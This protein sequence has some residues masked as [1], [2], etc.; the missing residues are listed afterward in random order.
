MSGTWHDVFYHSA[1]YFHL[2]IVL[3][4]CRDE[5]WVRDVPHLHTPNIF[6][7]VHIWVVGGYDRKSLCHNLRFFKAYT[8]RLLLFCRLCLSLQPSV[9]ICFLRRAHAFEP[10]YT[11]VYRWPSVTRKQIAWINLTFHILLVYQMS[12]SAQ[13]MFILLRFSIV[14]RPETHKQARPKMSAGSLTFAGHIT[15]KITWNRGG[16][17][18]VVYKGMNPRSAVKQ[19]RGV[20]GMQQISLS[21]TARA[22]RRII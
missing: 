18:V 6:S 8:N 21:Y 9:E 15:R 19:N 13:I 4:S 10:I 22:Q 14:L 17:L 20:S 3:S 2:Y 11:N 7:S 1:R 16:C 5:L 12:F